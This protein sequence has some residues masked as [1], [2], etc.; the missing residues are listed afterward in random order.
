MSETQITTKGPAQA[1]LVHGSIWRTIWVMSWPLLLSTITSS[2]VGLVDVKVAMQLGSAAQAAVGIAEHVVFIF[3]IFLMSVAVGTT[4][5]VSRAFGAEDKKL[6]LQGTAQSIS[7]AAMMG[8]AL[9]LFCLT[10]CQLF[11]KWF[12]PSMEVFSLAISYLMIY[13]FM[14]IPFAIHSTIGAAFRASGNA[15][16]PLIIVIVMTVI[17]IAGD[18]LTIY[19][20]WPI[21]N[22]GITGIAYSGLIANLVGMCIALLLLKFSN[23]GDSF[24]QILPFDLH[25]VRSVL[26]IGLPSAFQRLAWT[27]SF[28][29]VIFILKVCANPTEAIAALTIGIRIESILFMPLLAFTLALSSITGQNLGAQKYERAF[30]AGWQ[31]A[32]LGVGITI[33]LASLLFIFAQPLAQTLSNDSLTVNYT[34]N[35]LRITA[36]SEP[37]LA[38]G[39]ILGG[40]LQGAGDTK[41]PMW[42][43]LVT[44]SAVRLP[45]AW[46][47]A[48]HLGFGPTGAWL[49]M[50]ASVLCMA[51]LITIRYQSRAWMKI[52]V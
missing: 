17:N 21:A 38:L 39:M 51:L 18:F 29:L 13:S 40:A 34:A 35:Y 33:V 8:M 25:T 1:T 22:L 36:F 6:A 41:T 15:R 44:Q 11:I 16:T 52:K 4:A 31:T 7:L 43:T 50:A 47:L 2:F 37:L 14:L 9:L 26:K 42:I 32:A 49:A 10:T 12:A 30:K 20:N 28:A 23:L 19:G 45:L 24:K 27:V 48:L 46:L 3:M 5:L